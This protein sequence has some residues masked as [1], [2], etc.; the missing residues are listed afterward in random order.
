VTSWR[1]AGGAREKSCCAMSEHRLEARPVPARYG[2]LHISVV[3]T[4][5]LLRSLPRFFCAAPRTPLRVLGIIALDSLRTLRTSQPL[6]PKSID[7]LAMVLDFLGGTNAAWDHKDLCRKEYD[8]TRKRLRRGGLGAHVDAYL[9]RLR[10][11]EGRRPRIGGDRRR[12]DEVRSYR[13][14][15]ARLCVETAAAIALDGDVSG[16]APPETH[17]DNDVETLVRIL[18][19]CQIIDDVVDYT[20]DVSAGLPSF[21][22]ATGY[23]SQALELTSEAA[24][25][26]G[27]G[28]ERAPGGAIFPFRITLAL[29]TAAATLVVRLA[30]RRY[31]QDPNLEAACRRAGT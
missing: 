7:A 13:E 22:T 9:S 23:V 26:Y 27:G 3:V 12:F 21:L 10:D 1:F 25:S 29:F 20:H 19:Q 16:K 5:C 14:A 17:R 30:E 15:V 4:R 11:L 8:A 28:G 31:R 2:P 24:R 18:L 6:P